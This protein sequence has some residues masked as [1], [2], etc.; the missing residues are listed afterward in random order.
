MIFSKVSTTYLN[1]LH[2]QQWLNQYK[3]Q[4]HISII[5]KVSFGLIYGFQDELT[6][7]YV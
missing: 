7:K 4:E 6:I 5:R 1:I 3:Y 2:L